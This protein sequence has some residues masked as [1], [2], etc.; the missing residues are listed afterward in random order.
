MKKEVHEGQLR[1]KLAIII[2]AGVCAVIGIVVGVILATGS[3]KKS[4]GVYEV[5]DYQSGRD[6]F[7]TF[8]IPSI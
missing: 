6:N 8:Q 3:G 7:S 1:S 4:T 5:S 2:P